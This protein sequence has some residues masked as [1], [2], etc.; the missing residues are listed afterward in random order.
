MK[1][2]EP[3]VMD[4]LTKAWDRM[5]EM[6]FQPFEWKNWLIIG[7]VS[8]LVNCGRGGVGIGNFNTNFDFGG[9]GGSN[10]LQG[11]NTAIIIA[12]AL[13]ILLIVL[14]FLLASY[15][16]GSH[17]E[18]SL[19]S[20]I[21]NGQIQN[22]PLVFDGSYSHLANSLFLMKIA[23]FFIP[24]TLVLVAASIGVYLFYQSN[25]S[26]DFASLPLGLMI[27]AG[28]ILF[29]LGLVFSFISFLI[30][31]Y[32]IPIMLAK[33]I[34][35]FSALGQSFQLFSQ[36]P[37][38]GIFFLFLKFVLNILFG[39]ATFIAIFP[40][41]CICIGCI[42]IINVIA[43]CTILSPAYIL[44]SAFSL[45]FIEGHL[46]PNTIMKDPFNPGGGGLGFGSGPYN[47]PPPPADLRSQVYVQPTF[48]EYQAQQASGAYQAPEQPSEYGANPSPYEGNPQGDHSAGESYYEEAQ[49]QYAPQ[50]PPQN[51]G[52]YEGKYDQ[53]AYTPPPLPPPQDAYSAYA[54]PPLPNNDAYDADE[55][56]YGSADDSRYAVDDTEDS[57]SG[58]SG[59]YPP[60]PPPPSDYYP[61]EPTQVDEE[62]DDS[63]SAPRPSRYASEPP[64]LPPP[65]PE[66]DGDDVQDWKNYPPPP[67]PPPN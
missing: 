41:M 38:Q 62:N 20:K 40:L 63:P 67:P 48:D 22:N 29:L 50:D 19:V 10:P 14:V 45:Y 11:V 18:F 34:K 59:A 56:R 61:N 49:N 54:P 64:P 27:I 25:Q 5:M 51:T 6:M 15:Y 17:A 23:F 55:A 52:A 60:P 3:D 35:A 26:L 7:F 44:M 2:H 39:I 36:Y 4:S 47:G 46:G 32:T 66:D 9:G 12:A 30:N 24:T 43:I 21:S 13:V 57:A 37:L 31:N 1:T 42:P 28:L 16:V 53:S 33:D 8:F 65:V 58:D